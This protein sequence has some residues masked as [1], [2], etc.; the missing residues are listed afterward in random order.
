VLREGCKDYLQHTEPFQRLAFEHGS[1]CRS[2]IAVRIWV[3]NL[4][5]LEPN[6]SEFLASAASRTRLRSS[7]SVNDDENSA[8]HD[9]CWALIY[10]ITEIQ[11]APMVY[12]SE[13]EGGEQ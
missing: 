2:A 12:P 10:R 6:M 9:P 13:E 4:S 1:V 11:T 7:T 8:R 5:T 3:P